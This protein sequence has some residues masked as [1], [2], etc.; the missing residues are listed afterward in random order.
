MMRVFLFASR[1]RPYLAL[2]ASGVAGSVR[3][4]WASYAWCCKHGHRTARAAA[5]H[6]ARL[7][8]AEWNAA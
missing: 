2:M 6:G 4:Q 1:R 7:A 8:T 5:M 3:A